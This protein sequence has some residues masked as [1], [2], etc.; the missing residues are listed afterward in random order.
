MRSGRWQL[1][2]RDPVSGK[3]IGLGTYADRDLAERD[4]INAVADQNRGLWHDPRSGEITVAD[5]MARWLSQSR[6][7]GRHGVRYSREAERLAG[8]FI[9]P[10]LGRLMLV[11]LR[12]SIIAGWYNGQVADQLEKAGKVGLQPAKAYRLLHAALAD[13]VAAELI[14]RNPAVSRSAGVER[15]PERPLLEPAQIE[16]IAD[17]IVPW[18][19]GTVL[20]AAWCALRFGE[21]A[22]MRRRDVDLLHATLTIPKAKTMAGVRK[23]AVQAGLVPVLEEQLGRWSAPGPDGLVF[24][25]P[26]GGPMNPGNFTRDF[27]RAADAVGLAHVHF[28]DLRHA[29]GTF[30]AQS[31]ATER[32]LMARLGHSSPEAA[33]RYQHAAE[34][35]DRE[36]ADRLEAMFS[37]G[38][39][40]ELN[41][42]PRRKHGQPGQK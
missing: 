41:A 30:A 7:T 16:A 12:P 27:R 14:P 8:V 24:V 23:V 39:S 9:L 19:R 21:V 3:Q 32:E 13:A 2:I 34:R 25:G 33:R 6:R 35:R 31:G 26:K 4:G 28:H 5:H 36:I 20:V 11:D 10:S 37:R 18:W 40:D 42:H 29:G 38:R 15:S 1:L 22:A 17:E